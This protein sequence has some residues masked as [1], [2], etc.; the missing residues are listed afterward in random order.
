MSYENLNDKINKISNRTRVIIGLCVIA[1]GL[2]FGVWNFYP[3]GGQVAKEESQPT[4]PVETEEEAKA[5]QAH[6]DFFDTSGFKK[7]Y[8][9][10]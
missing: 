8:E 10:Y 6:K 2:L 3:M 7:Q 9:G 1:G 4:T 5:R